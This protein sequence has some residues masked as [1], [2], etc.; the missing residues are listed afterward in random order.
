[1]NVWIEPAEW[2]GTG[3][4]PIAQLDVTSL[5]YLDQTTVKGF[6]AV[7][8][9]DAP[10]S[11]PSTVYRSFLDTC[12]SQGHFTGRYPDQRRPKT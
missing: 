6:Q 12:V 5:S 2:S 10:C 3:I 11:F 4:R 9:I 1:M 7:S 8:T